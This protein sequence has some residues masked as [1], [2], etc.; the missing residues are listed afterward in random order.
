MHGTELLF[1]GAHR[2][3]VHFFSEKWPA[4]GEKNLKKEKKYTK[5]R[6]KL[7]IF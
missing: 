5:N 7:V 4:A 1:L 2:S 6:Q 3:Q